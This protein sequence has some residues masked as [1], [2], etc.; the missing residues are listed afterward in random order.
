MNFEEP[1]SINI[2]ESHSHNIDQK[3]GLIQKILVSEIMFDATAEY[4]IF[5]SKMN[6]L[7]IKNTDHIK[8]ISS[9]PQQK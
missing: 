3:T 8:Q 4:I 5:Q 7:G 6:Y 9:I 1:Q 2:V